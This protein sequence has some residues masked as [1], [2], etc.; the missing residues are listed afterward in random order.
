MVVAASPDED[1][2]DDTGVEI[3]TDNEGRPAAFVVVILIVVLIIVGI[4]AFL[5]VRGVRPPKRLMEDNYEED[6]ASEG[7]VDRVRGL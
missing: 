5:I 3:D 7:H 6:Q 4:V 2:D 1:D